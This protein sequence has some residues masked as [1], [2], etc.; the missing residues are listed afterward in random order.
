MFDLI[1]TQNLFLAGLREAVKVTY[2]RGTK[3]TYPGNQ[4]RYTL[5]RKTCCTYKDI[6]TGTTYPKSND[7]SE[8]EEF[9]AEIRGFITTKKYITR[10]EA[11]F[12]LQELN[13]TYLPFMS[14]Q[15]RNSSKLN[16]K[17]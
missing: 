1:S 10:K 6:F 12:I 13:P 17:R 4:I 8:G 15:E 9:C 5:V 7:V 14:E 3:Y 2:N 11:I 16:L